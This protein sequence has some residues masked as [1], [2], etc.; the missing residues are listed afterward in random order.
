MVPRGEEHR[1]RRDLLESRA[2]EFSSV[3]CE[4][5]LLIKVTTAAQRVHVQFA[6][7]LADT[8]E[9][10]AQRPAPGTGQPWRRPAKGRIQVQVGKMQQPHAIPPRIIATVAQPDQ[11]RRETKGPFIEG[12][13]S[14][15]RGIA[16]KIRLERQAFRSSLD[17]LGH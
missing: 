1:E 3:R 4:P 9:R 16:A 12:T 10:V 7:E 6:S 8:N 17:K 11:P 2:Q 15:L 13:L 5:L 14:Q